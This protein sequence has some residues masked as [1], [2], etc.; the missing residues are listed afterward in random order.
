MGTLF[1]FSF[2]VEIPIYLSTGDTTVVTLVGVGYHQKEH[3][4]GQSSVSDDR[5]KF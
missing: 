2:K 1:F 5:F 3:K 4:L